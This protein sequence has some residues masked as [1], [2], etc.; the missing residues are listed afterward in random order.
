MHS[1]VVHGASR[2]KKRGNI[3]R[4]YIF[5]SNS[6]H[7]ISVKIKASLDFIHNKILR[8]NILDVIARR[9]ECVTAGKDGGEKSGRGREIFTALHVS[10]PVIPYSDLSRMKKT[11]KQKSMRRSSIYLL[12]INI[13]NRFLMKHNK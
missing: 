8:S 6:D 2:Q 5:I 11:T 7:F 4:C 13:S 1:R 10:M 3:T 9:R 12:T